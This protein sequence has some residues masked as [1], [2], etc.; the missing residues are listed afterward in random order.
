[1]GRNSGF[2]NEEEIVIAL[3]DKTL[4]TLSNKNLVA[5]IKDL[6]PNI[7]LHDKI[8]CTLCDRQ[9]I[10]INNRKQSMNPKQD[11]VIIVNE[12]E[13]FISVK[14]GSGNSVHEEKLETFID[15]LV[16]ELQASD[17]VVKSLKV[18]H[19]GDGTLDGTASPEKRLKGKDITITYAKEMGIIHDF[20]KE[21][22]RKIIE[23]VLLHGAHKEIVNKVDFIYHG[24][25]ESGVWCNIDYAIEVNQEIE[26]EKSPISIGFFSFQNQNRNTTQNPKKESARKSIQFKWANMQSILEKNME[27]SSR[28]N[29]NRIEKGNNKHGFENIDL[30]MKALNGQA[31][32]KI[33]SKILSAFIKD[34]F[35][36]DFFKG[37]IICEK[38]NST[39]F[40]EEGNRIPQIRGL[41]EKGSLDITLGKVTKRILIKSGASNSIHQ[42][43]F[44]QFYSFLINEC[45]ATPNIINDFKLIQWGDGTLDG[46]TSPESWLKAS[47]IKVKY[48][49]EVSRVQNFLTKEEVALKIMKR[50]LLTGSNLKS[51][52]VD[53]VFFGNPQSGMW[54]KVEDI[55]Q[56]EKEN[57]S[58]VNKNA[59]LNI[60]NITLQSWGR[61]IKRSNNSDQREALQ[62][63]YAHLEKVVK[64]VANK[65]ISYKVQGDTAEENFVK[66]YNINGAKLEKFIKG[67]NIYAVQVDT[68]QYSNLSESKVNPKSDV[69]LIHVQNGIEEQLLFEQDYILKESD[70]KNLVYESINGSGVS[71]KREDSQNYTFVKLTKNSFEKLFNGRNEDFIASMFYVKNEIEFNKNKEILDSYGITIEEI[72]QKLNGSILKDEKTMY[73]N[74]KET[75]MQNIKNNILQDKEIYESIFFGTNVF[76]EPYAASYFY[77]DELIFKE[78]LK[79]EQFTITTGSGRSKGNYTIVVKP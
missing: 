76:E 2:E 29:K 12:V 59:L 31:V 52:E 11:I 7:T 34:I 49:N 47:E 22:K 46:N 8:Y 71:V 67:E 27:F 61:S 9:V 24:S 14:K 39:K 60:G 16:K 20:F 33:K 5:F 75:A 43:S 3:N 1:M 69:Y 66:K 37:I 57:L 44:E 64:E 53:Y 56:F 15:F 72:S 36:G 51:K 55:I 70:L 32:G 35:K 13:K 25:V 10:E 58:K 77:R 78:D 74:S 42:E 73:K 63:K 40:D 30:I 21:N 54:T 6:F 41:K 4:K 50:A 79:I 65:T 26:N 23:R 62:I 45:N 18:F 68:K 28:I 48:K 38:V 17:E 19:W